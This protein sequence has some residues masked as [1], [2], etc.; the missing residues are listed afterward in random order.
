MKRPS[1]RMFVSAGFTLLEIV[2]FLT[3]A[4][5]VLPLI[6]APFVTAVSQSEDPEIV[7]AANASCLLQILAEVHKQKAKIRV[8]HTMDLLDLS[9]RDASL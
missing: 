1:A 6:I 8:M 2:V 9:Y 5:I 4:G 3:I 7:L